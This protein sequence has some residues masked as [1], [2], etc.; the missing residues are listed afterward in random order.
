MAA[1][2]CAADLDDWLTESNEHSNRELGF[3]V[4][5][6]RARGLDLIGRGH[7]NFLC[8]GGFEIPSGSS[9]KSRTV[10]STY[11]FPPAFAQRDHT[12]LF[13]QAMITEHVTHSWFVDYEGGKHPYE[14]NTE[15]YASGKESHKYSWA[16][17]PRYNDLPAETGALADMLACENPLFI[18]LINKTGANALVRQLARIVRPAELLNAMS[19]WLAEIDL[20]SPFY[21]SP[22]DVMTGQGFG[23]T[24]APRGALGHWIQA[25][26]GAI[27][28]YQ[29]I[30]PT[31]W[32]GSPRD[33]AGIRGPWE[34]A[35]V[36]TSVNNPENPVEV[37]H[38]I[39]S[40]DPCLVCTVH[41]VQPCQS[42]ERKGK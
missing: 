33:A 5:A 30:T 38:V 34:E 10:G 22:P 31:S 20:R 13:D 42:P 9:V 28:R 21:Q 25:S 12:E 37:G 26:N 18:D 11:L 14:G 41:A 2:N 24:Q 36:G 32:N 17:A 35:L 1:V 39:R 27:D 23:I 4:R 29:I 7:D 6:A 19:T 16:K 40:F 15:P 8:S 3:F